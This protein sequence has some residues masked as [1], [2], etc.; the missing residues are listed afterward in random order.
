MDSKKILDLFTAGK[1]EE[2][3]KELAMLLENT[4]LSEEDRA[5]FY[6]ELTMLY[7]KIKHDTLKNYDDLLKTLQEN[8]EKIAAIELQ[9]DKKEK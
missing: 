5:K 2:V 4:K 1:K 6:L 3:K 7:A 9:L 8:L